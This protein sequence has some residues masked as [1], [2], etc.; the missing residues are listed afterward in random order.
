MHD[1][2]A[3][4]VPNRS[5]VVNASRLFAERAEDVLHEAREHPTW[6]EVTPH[7]MTLVV[8]GRGVVSF[9]VDRGSVRSSRLWG[10]HA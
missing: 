4:S 2:L 1:R 9:P 3:R 5:I 10:V 8:N 6:L 7:R